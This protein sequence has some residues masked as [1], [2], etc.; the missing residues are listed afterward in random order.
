MIA[1]HARRSRPAIEAWRRQRGEAPLVVVLTGTD[2]YR[3]LPAGDVDTRR[4]LDDADRIVVLQQDAV[5]HLPPEVRRKVDVVHQSARTLKPFADKRTDRLNA[6]LVA[7]LRPEKD[8]QTL[9]DAWRSVPRELPM[10]LAVIG[11]PLD[12]KLGDAAR[13]LAHDDARVQ[14][15]GARPHAWTRQAIKRAH[16]VVVPSRMEGG[17]NVIVEAITAATPVIASRVSGNVGMLGEAYP[18]YFAPGDPAALAA[19]LVRACRQPDWLAA[20]RGACMQRAHLF[21]PDAERAA[22]AD[23]LARATAG[24]PGRMLRSTTPEDAR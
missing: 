17:A 11:A 8:P 6:L 18:G 19:S 2:L 9:F 12:A 20:L 24:T 21:D 22:L 10:S 7:H 13:A 14:V 5:R 4:S 16:L 1:L 23:V 3:D 15:L